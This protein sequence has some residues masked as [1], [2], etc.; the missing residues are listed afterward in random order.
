MFFAPCLRQEPPHSGTVHRARFPTRWTF[1]GRGRDR[2]GQRH[3]APGRRP[4]RRQPR[5]LR[6]G[7]KVH[8]AFRL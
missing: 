2:G 7:T 8:R 4:Q 5:L 1:R 3:A 6:S